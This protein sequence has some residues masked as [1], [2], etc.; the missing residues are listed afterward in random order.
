MAGRSNI[1]LPQRVRLVPFKRRLARLRTGNFSFYGLVNPR[2][3]Y[4]F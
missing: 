1:F 3:K 2:K 4:M